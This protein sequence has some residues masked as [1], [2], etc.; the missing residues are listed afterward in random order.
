MSGAGTGT[1]AAGTATLSCVE[2]ELI[3]SCHVAEV[4]LVRRLILQ[5]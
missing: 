2:S 4:L 1:S 3:A 5:F